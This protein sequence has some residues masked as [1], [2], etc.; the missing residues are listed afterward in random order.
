MDGMN[1]LN[2]RPN[3]AGSVGSKIKRPSEFGSL[4]V[5]NEIMRIAAHNRLFPLQEITKSLA[6]IASVPGGRNMGIPISTS[7]PEI[8]ANIE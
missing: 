3:L 5:D 1:L 7:L 6:S 2:N 4:W 8:S